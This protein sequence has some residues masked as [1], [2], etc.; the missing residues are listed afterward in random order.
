MLAS[1]IDSQRPR[2]RN[3][4]FIQRAYVETQQASQ[5]HSKATQTGKGLNSLVDNQKANGD[6]N[7]CGDS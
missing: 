6:F 2:R 1:Y 4:H 3:R 5:A 7:C